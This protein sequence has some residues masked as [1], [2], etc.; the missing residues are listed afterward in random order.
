MNEIPPR[1]PAVRPSPSPRGPAVRPSPS[2]R[3]PAARPSPSRTPG[4]PPFFIVGSA[5]SGTTWLRIILNA[6]S[7]VAVPPESRFI[8]SL[9]RGRDD[10]DAAALLTRLS[11]HKRFR[12]WG[13]PIAEVERAL[14]ERATFAQ[15]VTAAY[16]A[17]ARTRGKSRWGDKTPR[18][19][20]HIPLLARLFPDSLFIHQIRDGRDVAL[21]YADVPFGPKSV[22]AA[23]ELWAARVRA[24][25][26][27]GG[28]LG[29]RRYTEI[30]YE[31]F[32][33]EPERHTRVLCEFLGLRFEP[34][35]L[36]SER[37]KKDILPRAALYNL[38]VAKGTNA[39]P[40]SWEHDMPAAHVE[41]FEAVAGD[42]L[43]ELG[44]PRRFES[45]GPRARVAAAA[46]RRGLPVARLRR[47]T[48]G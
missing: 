5:R 27:A 42:L 34:E 19:V 31:A 37:A 24:G 10:V 33:A 15:V 8:V 7:Q 12:E 25:A 13:L 46:G 23:A 39:K 45:P 2:P 9:W 41:I 1:R 29:P 32:V 20:E 11:A 14:P 18:Y 16:V 6:H 4:G 38:N 48:P 28:A 36:D 21:S 43:S 47:A 30:R 40:R 17:Y 44:Y 26:A 22:A 3:S 35:M